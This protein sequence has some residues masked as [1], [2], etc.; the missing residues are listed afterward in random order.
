[1]QNGKSHENGAGKCK[2]VSDLGRSGNSGPQ[3]LRK[4]LQE[5]YGNELFGLYGKKINADGGIRSGVLK[6]TYH[7]GS[8]QNHP[9][10]DFTDAPVRIP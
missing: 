9:P 2:D 7:A 6:D 8:L 1:M 3:L 5:V 10:D 4:M